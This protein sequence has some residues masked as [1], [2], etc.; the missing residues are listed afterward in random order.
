MATTKFA[1]T[2]A[3]TF[4]KD[5][6][7]QGVIYSPTLAYYFTAISESDHPYDAADAAYDD[8]EIRFDCIDE[9]GKKFRPMAI[10][11]IIV[12]IKE[13]APQAT[14]ENENALTI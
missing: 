3:V 4:K 10:D 7:H 14:V 5:F 8:C 9:G 13:V 12:G 2:Y 11:P 1:V 6:I